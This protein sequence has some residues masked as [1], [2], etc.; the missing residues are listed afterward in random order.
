MREHK[1]GHLGKEDSTKEMN[2]L[3]CADKECVKDMVTPDADLD[4][5]DDYGDAV[6]S[7]NTEE[8]TE[9]VW[10]L[11]GKGNKQV[12]VNNFVNA[13]KSDPLLN[14][15]LAYDML[16]ETIV[17]TRPS[18]TAKGSKKGDLVSDTDISII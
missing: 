3:V 1:F 11:D 17:F 6:K 16:K 13:F 8:V 18:F 10:D 14:G 12:T 15:L 5:F 7:D 9:L 2:K 4:D